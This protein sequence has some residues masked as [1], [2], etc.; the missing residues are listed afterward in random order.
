MLAISNVIGIDIG[1]ATVAVAEISRSGNIVH[2]AYGFHH[3]RP[4]ETLR[5]ILDGIDLRHI[6]GIAATSSTPMQ[7]Q[8][9]H[10]SDNQVAIIRAARHYYPQIRSILTIGAEKYGLIQLDSNGNYRTFRTN[11]GCAAGTGSFIDQQSRRLNLPDAA[12]LSDL[13][14]RNTGALP[15]IASRCAVF[16]KTDLIHAQQEGYQLEEICDGLCHGLAK[17]VVDILFSGQTPLGPILLMGGVANNDAVVKHIRALV[18]EEII[19]AHY[20]CGAAGAALGLMYSGYTPQNH[21]DLDENLLT[22]LDRNEKKPYHAPI[23]LNLSVYPDFSSGMA[24]KDAHWDPSNPV[25]VDLY[26]DTETFEQHELLLGFDIGSTSSKAVLLAVDGRVVAGFYTRTAGRPA[27]ATQ[28]LLAAVDKLLSEHDLQ[29]AIKGVGTTGSGRKFAGAILGADVVLDEITAHA[30]AAVA[31]NPHVDTIIEI[32]GQDAKFTTL[33]NGRV[34]FSTMNAVCAAGTG[35]FIEE[36]AEKLGCALEDI[37]ARTR[38]R[39][40]PLASDR[41]TVFME[42]D[43]NHYLAEGYHVEEVLAAVLHSVVENYLNKVAI[44]TSIGDNVAFQGAT[45]KNKSLVAALEARLQKPI[46]VSRYCHLTGAMAALTLMEQGVDHTR[47]KGLHLYQ[48]TIPVRSEICELCA[49]HCKITVAQ[50]AGT[51]EAYGFLC[52]RDYGD[53]KRPPRRTTG[54]DIPAE[55]RKAHRTPKVIEPVRATTVGMPAALH[56]AEDL[57]MWRHFFHALGMQTVTSENCKD[58][59]KMGKPFTGAE[60]CAP[61]TALY[62]HVR[63]LKQRCDHIFL[64]FY[65]EKRPF[66]KEMR[67]QYCYYTQYAPSLVAEVMGDRTSTRISTPLVEYLYNDFFIKVQLHRMLKK[68][69]RQAVSFLEVSTAYD[70][71][72]KFRQTADQR[73]KTVY[74]Q[75]VRD[76]SDLHVVLLGRPYTVLSPSMNKGIPDIFTG[77]G[78]QVF[79]QHMLT[80][81]SDDVSA[82]APLLADVHWNYAAQILEAAE[83]TARTPS[84]YPVLV[85]SFKCTPDS[86]IIDYFKK[87]MA[88]HKKPFAILQLDEH[89]SNVGYE[90]RI[91]AAVA[92]FKE[93]YGKHQRA[94]KTPRSLTSIQSVPVTE[95]HYRT[96]VFPNWDPTAQRLMVANLRRNGFDAHLLEGSEAS[97]RKSLRMNNGQCMPLTIIAQEYVDFIKTHDLD[98]T[99]TVL[100]LSAAKIACNIGLF[101]RHIQHLLQAQGKG[102][103]KAGL[104]IGHLSLA[105]ISMKLPLN[106]YLAYMFGGLLKKMAC[107]IRPYEKIAGTTDRVLEQSLLLLESVFASSQSKEAALDQVVHWFD[108]IERAP[109]DPSRP[110]PKVA[111]FGDLYVRDNEMINQG[112]I[113]FIEAQGGEVVTTP[114]SSYLKMIVQPYLRKWFVEGRYLEALSSKAFIA[115]VSRLEKTYYK[116]FQRVLQEPEPI[117]DASAQEILSAYGVRIENNG[118]SMENL[119]KIHYLKK[120]HPDI[121][122]FIQTNPAFCCPSLVTEAMAS[123]IEKITQTPIVSIT[124]DGIGGNKNDVLIPYLKFPRKAAVHFPGPMRH[125]IS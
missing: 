42:R 98:P 119:L 25:E 117:Y 80:Y 122:L 36:Q 24:Y 39:P 118:E 73:L 102:M 82:I 110:R 78:V 108:S 65:L 93:H 43:V 106:T 67:R 38:G 40:A 33:Q 101:V 66:R 54:V 85:T 116:Y 6:G 123:T 107:L 22:A 125:K 21:L 86:F 34:T 103:E 100:W 72:L 121:A 3:G 31:L 83:V 115:T 58:A 75:Y 70:R 1:S 19:V 79:H 114:Y 27:Q 47:F 28:N 96:L 14:M 88:A 29:V 48:H 26:L 45:A 12:A 91:E 62:G 99:R 16:A 11:T 94:I 74:Q 63:H 53:T 97:T 13:A 56:L 44:E 30:K 109:T 89:D 5:R 10:R 7:V 57:P 23:E 49:N 113:H 60:F 104:Y 76:R 46:F 112:L 18:D 124:Y 8:A 87:V 35:S 41:C 120:L 2:W 81:T 52:G 50:V 71:A 17:N 9:S 77:L 84:A 32:G 55:L 20:P 37:A 105:D 64:P 59:V 90:T 15:K 61:M 4:L 111:I 95:L 69:F 68:E 51:E 92:A